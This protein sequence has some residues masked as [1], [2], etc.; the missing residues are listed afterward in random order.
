MRAE[1]MAGSLRVQPGTPVPDAL[2]S[3]RRDWA[4]RL[5]RGQS[6][7]ALPG[8]LASLFSL[9]SHAHRLCA[10]L[11]IS[12][13]RPGV[14]AAPTNVA[15]RLRL[16][17]AQ[18]HVR[19]IGLD[20]PRLLAGAP[21]PAALASLQISPLLRP[22]GAATE[23]DWSTSL[24]WFE[25]EWLQMPAATLLR[26]WQACGADWLIDW[27]QR[28]TGWLPSLVRA[29]READTGSALDMKHAMRA[30]ADQEGQRRL[31]DALAR[32]PGFAMQ[33]QW[34]SACAHTG[35][36]SR[37]HRTDDGLPLT[38][39]AMLGCRL[40]ELA[41]LC[42]PAPQ[43]GTGWLAHGA[44]HLT[45][46]Q[47]LAWVEM[48]RGLL[49]HQVA[50]DGSDGTAMVQACRVLAPTEWN[51]HPQ[52]AVAQRIAALDPGLPEALLHRQLALLMVAFDPCVPFHIDTAQD[53][54]Q[55]VSH[56]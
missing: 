34:E 19:R 37:L 41:R 1:D 21:V 2:H 29:A 30:H 17:T 35:T 53:Q 28:H 5:A 45:D 16:E 46:G 42:L 50:I 49:V 3:E 7:T 10:Q 44:L 9:C 48:A 20:W 33:P 52:G 13:A 11:A 51:F 36:W 47:G 54:T 55:E 6:A 22:A 23:H 31:A 14:M 39:W 32:T 18:E 8:L 43:D 27:S 40:A 15:Q 24:A 25:S 4:S 38:P 56:A 26:A 12:A